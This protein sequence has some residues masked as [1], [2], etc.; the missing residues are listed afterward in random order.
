MAWL[1][2]V[3]VIAGVVALVALLNAVIATGTGNK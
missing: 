1:T 2:V 3:V